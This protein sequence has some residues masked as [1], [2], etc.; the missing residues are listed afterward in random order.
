MVQQLARR[1]K[2]AEGATPIDWATAEALAFGSLLLEGS[3]IRMSGQDSARGTFS[4]RH[5]VFHD[6]QTGKTWTPLCTLAECGVNPSGGAVGE[7]QRPSH[8]SSGP[9][10]FQIYDS[11]LSETGVLGFE[12][13]Y[14]VET[15]D[16]LVIWE[17]QYGD[18]ANGAQVI[19][20]QFVTSAEDKWR[21]TSR[22]TL[23]L[24]HGYEGQGPEHSSARIER[25]LQLC[26]DENLRVCNV[27]TPAQYFHVL[28]RQLRSSTAKPLIL[29]TPKSLLRFPTSFSALDALATG[30]FHPVLDDSEVSDKRAIERV[31]LSAGKVFY[32]LHHARSERKDAK[33]ALLRLEQF[34]PFPSAAL[35]DLLSTYPSLREIVWVQEEAQNMGGWTFIHPRLVSL[36]PSGIPLRYAGRPASASPATGNATVHKQELAELLDQAFGRSSPSPG[37]RG[38]G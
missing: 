5:V 27:T 6:T 23:F 3:S 4:Q 29:F 19:L 18:F 7:G 14:S 30:A 32:D 20:D 12:Y 1:A 17:A 31:T 15:P 25:Y 16:S 26:A 34:Y 37:G 28:R 33:T 11:P 22:L 35:R 36:L 21:E 2:M 9:A 13:G 24:P 8:P 38:R 10:T